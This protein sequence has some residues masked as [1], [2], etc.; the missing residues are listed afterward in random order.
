M[1]KKSVLVGGLLNLLFPGLADVYVAR[2]GHAI[3]TFLGAVVYVGVL[4][5][6]AGPADHT[7]PTWPDFVC[8]GLAIL[9]YVVAIFASGMAS[10]RKY[11]ESHPWGLCPYC[12]QRIRRDAA[13][14]SH[15]RKPLSSLPPNLKIE[16]GINLLWIGAGIIVVGL[17]VLVGVFGRGDAPWTVSVPEARDEDIAQAMRGVSSNDEWTPVGQSFDGVTMALVPAGC[18]MMGSEDGYDDET[19]VHEQCFDEPFW[20]DVYEVT[21]AQYGSAGRFSGDNHPRENVNWFDA[22]AHCENRGARLPTEA[23]WEYAARGPDNL[24]YPWGN[25][26]RADFAYGWRRTANVGSKPRGA[27]WVGALDMSG[28][29]KEWVSSIHS[30]YPHSATDGREADSSSDSNSLRVLRGGSWVNADTRF[31]R[32]ANRSSYNPNVTSDLLGFRCARSFSPADVPPDVPTLTAPSTEQALTPHELAENGVSSNEG[33][34]PYIEYF[35]GVEMALVP[36]GCFMMGDEH[37]FNTGPVHE[38]CFDEPFWI[39]VCEVTNAQYGSEGEYSGDNRPRESVIWFD[40]TAHC[41]R[42]GARLPTE[43]EWEYAARGPDGLVYPWG[44]DFESDYI[45]DTAETL[46]V[47]SKPMG[48]S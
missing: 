34:T 39:D 23:E 21:N 44:N 13:V 20:I 45:W 6:V 9:V 29:V 33:W 32:A 31:L 22:A 7:N 16:N 37:G 18:F 38:Q 26:F 47:G 19:P 5:Y 35:N 41:Q 11:N 28:N 48:V 25:D 24:Q 46:D 8:P 4:L 14:C 42:R 27:S 3:G 43:A 40:A 17:L 15:C 1:Q 2:W 10:V 12:R 30:P 36:A